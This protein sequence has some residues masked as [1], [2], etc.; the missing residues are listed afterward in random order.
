MSIVKIDYLRND[1]Y[2]NEHTYEDLFEG[3]ELADQFQYVIYLEPFGIYEHVNDGYTAGSCKLD[4]SSVYTVWNFM[5]LMEAIHFDK[6]FEL[7]DYANNSLSYYNKTLSYKQLGKEIILQTGKGECIEYVSDIITAFKNAN[8]W[9]AKVD[10]LKIYIANNYTRICLD[11]Y[12][13]TFDDVKQ[14]MDKITSNE[15]SYWKVFNSFEIEY[16]HAAGRPGLFIK[17]TNDNSNF[18]ILMSPND[19]Y[20]I[21]LGILR[22]KENQ[23]INKIISN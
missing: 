13:F 10:K 4:D 12:S 14:I 5:K 23:Q 8:K 7:K 9:R 17:S 11:D 22:A 20:L 2:R 18:G 6:D 21:L 15:G 3:E 1:S 16:M 19:A